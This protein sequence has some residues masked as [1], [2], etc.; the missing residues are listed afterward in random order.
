MRQTPKFHLTIGASRFE[1][2][3]F[4]P[5]IFKTSPTIFNLSATTLKMSSTTSNSSARTLPSSGLIFC[6]QGAIRKNRPEILDATG[7]I[8]KAEQIHLSTFSFHGGRM[9]DNPSPYPDLES[10]LADEDFLLW[11][12]N[13]RDR[14]RLDPPDLIDEMMAAYDALLAIEDVILAKENELAE[15]CKAFAESQ[16]ALAEAQR[17]YD[18]ARQQADEQDAASAESD[19]D[20]AGSP[21]SKKKPGSA[22]P[23]S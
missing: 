1:I 15:A 9:P 16:K 5:T 20:E 19:S 12:V 6:T 3:N 23:T 21:D 7:I 10:Q 2:R 18:Q 14:L 17:A 4:S 13:N 11:V 8:C 22:P